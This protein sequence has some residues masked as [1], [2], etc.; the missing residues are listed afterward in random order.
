MGEDA[1]QDVVS[2]ADDQ[3]DAFDQ[4]LPLP[5]AVNDEGKPVPLL[6]VE[7]IFLTGTTTELVGLVP[8]DDTSSSSRSTYVPKE[9]LLGDI[10]FRG[11]ISDFY[12]IKQK[13]IDADYDP[14]LIR[15]NEDDVYGD[16]NN[17]EVA[18]T[19]DAATVWEFIE[20]ETERRR[21]AEEEAAAKKA[22]EK[23]IPRS[24]R[25]REIKPWASRG[26][27]VEIE[28]ASVKSTREP[29]RVV[30]QR[31]RRHFA[32]PC[33]FAD[34]DAHE[35]WNSSQMECRPFKDP[36]YDLKRTEVECGIQAVPVLCSAA[37]Q[38]T[39]APPR[40]NSNQYVPQDLL[41]EAKQQL[42]RSKEVS[43]FLEKV[44]SSCEEALVQNEITNIFQD[45][46][47][48]LAE[49]DGVSGN[50]RETS[51]QEYQSF[52]DLIYS[53]NKVVTA[54]QWLPHKRGFVAVACAEPLSHTERISRM[55][56]PTPSYILVWNFRDPIHPE[57]VLESP[58]EVFSFQ[59]NP[60]NPEVV[61]AGC[62]SGQVAMWDTSAE[63]ER[64]AK[65]NNSSRDDGTDDA[66]V[67][68]VRYKAMSSVEF[69][70]HALVM[71]LQWLPGVEITRDGRVTKLADG[72]RECSFFAT[73][74]ADGKVMF[75]DMR[76]E[77]LL[78]K[79]RKV[80]DLDLVWKPTHCVPLISV[81][82][83]DLACTR[84][85]FKLSDLAAGHFYVGTDEGE[86]VFADFTKQDSDDNPDYA[87]WQA[88]T[89]AGSIVAMQRSPF[90]EDVLLSVGDWSFQ[91]WHEGHQA[92]IFISPHSDEYYTAACW[93]PTRPG[94]YFLADQSGN[95][96]VWDLLDRSHEPCMQLSA[97]SVAVM[98]AS[99]PPNAGSSTSQQL[100]AVG[101]CFGVLHI[102]EVPRNLR[103][104]VQNE[105]KLVRGFLDREIARVQ[106]V[107]ARQAVRAK[108][109]KEMEEAKKAKEDAEEAARDAA[110]KSSQRR[111]AQAEAAEKAEREYRKLEAEL[112]V[113][114]G[115]VEE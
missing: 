16:G 1:N 20:Q 69:S 11:A 7:S 75:W 93:S 57:Y 102:L 51:L 104:P 59:Y 100:M 103:R 4:Q 73:T 106:D 13:V 50:R 41:P 64:I 101:D 9:K 68:V 112:K 76:L 113:Q 24:Q 92:P 109:L 115:I 89:H 47:A 32:Q 110:E 67:P 83:M 96:Q 62:Y 86:V 95:L 2:A 65:Q 81:Q 46:F 3:Q 80:D 19:R 55:G 8:A 35:L 33:K 71:D 27:E 60:A 5:Y 44:K 91:I 12:S 58:S 52:T 25:K 66:A 98:S 6:G 18:L 37:V 72:S 38:A 74:A 87:R 30:A 49:E 114:L 36:N 107:L 14:I 22:A 17:Y 94:V 70:H 28:D 54:I 63:H 40:N 53:K 42:L 99:F 79:G 97:S 21:A 45:D 88:V 78:K 31:R 82:G 56:R 90:F 84:L 23:L 29:I 105:K 111:D 39:P 48:A 15:R 61:T 85:S 77:K 34:K 43:T 10:Q 26:S 108:V